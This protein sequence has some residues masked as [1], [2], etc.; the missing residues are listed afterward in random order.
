MKQSLLK[1]QFDALE[2]PQNAL[3]VEIAAKPESIASSIVREMK[4]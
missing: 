4:L 1:S 3:V 2:E